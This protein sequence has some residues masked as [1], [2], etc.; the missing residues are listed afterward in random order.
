[1]GGSFSNYNG[2]YVAR[3]FGDHIMPI[4]K[5]NIIPLRDESLG[6]S[7]LVHAKY[8]VIDFDLESLVTTIRDNYPDDSTWKIEVDEMTI[9]DFIMQSFI[10]RI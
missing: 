3:V 2:I 9:K 5:G 1:M 7:T 6:N 4:L 10:D 8:S